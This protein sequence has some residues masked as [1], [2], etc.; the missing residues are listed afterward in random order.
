MFAQAQAALG[1]LDSIVQVVRLGG[2]FNVGDR[3]DSLPQAMNGASD[4]MA[5]VFGA[6]GRHARTTVGVAHLPL[7]AMSEI[8][9]QASTPQSRP[10]PAASSMPATRAWGSTARTR[11]FQAAR[12]GRLAGVDPLLGELL[13]RKPRTVRDLLAGRLDEARA[14]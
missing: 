4:L 10:A 2:F 13:G 8:E 9:A 6:R 5:E 11:T 1:D 7:N 12:E 3:F 14:R